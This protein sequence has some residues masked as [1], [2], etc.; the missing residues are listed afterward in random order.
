[1]STSVVER[2]VR[3]RIELSVKEAISSI[4]TFRR[5]ARLLATL[6]DKRINSLFESISD[7]DIFKKSSDV[8]DDFL[9]ACSTKIVEADKINAEELLYLYFNRQPPFGDGKKKAEF[10]DAISLLSLKSYLHDKE[11]YM[12]YLMIMI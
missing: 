3:A 12:L 6:D 2:E 5:K 7:E 10:P 4:Q 11:K 9:Y 1:M 8:F